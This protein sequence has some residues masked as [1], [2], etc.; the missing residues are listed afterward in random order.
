MDVKPLFDDGMRFILDNAGLTVPV[1]IY[2]RV[3]NEDDYD[4]ATVDTVTG[5]T[6]ISGLVLP[7]NGKMGSSEAVLLEQGK[8]LLQD[9]VMYCG[10][11]ATSGDRIFKIKND[12]FTIIND[13]IK[14]YDLIGSTV[15]NKL[16]L[17]YL[18]NGSLY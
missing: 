14:T 4:D 3:L 13:G 15:Y 6:V 1:T 2:N 17:R 16:F 10:S 5:S 8:L 11:I 18:P 9:K 12:Y 7:I